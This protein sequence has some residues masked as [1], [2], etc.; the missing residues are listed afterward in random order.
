M[1]LTVSGDITRAEPDRAGR[2]AIR[3]K[4]FVFNEVS[5]EKAREFD[6]PTSRSCRRRVHADFPKGG[7][8]T[9]FSGPLLADVLAAAGAE[10][11]W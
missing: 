9:E 1:L 2:S 3:D 11:R 10:A 6:L 5:F 8:E 4:L 7:A